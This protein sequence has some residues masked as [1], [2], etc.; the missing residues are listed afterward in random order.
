MREFGSE[1]PA[2]ILP[3]GYFEN[4]QRPGREIVH[5][6]SGREALLLVALNCK[7]ADGAVI[8]IPA[9][10]CWSMSA[11]FEKSG[12]EIVY[13]RLNEDLTPDEGY[14][15][16]VLESRRPAAILTMNFYGSAPTERAVALARE[17]CPGITII[18]DFSHCTFCF[19]RIFNPEVDFYVSSIRKSVGVCDGAIIIGR[20][21]LDTRLIIA[22]ESGF[23]DLR[24][25]AQASKDRYFHTKDP[26]AKQSFLNDLRRCETQ[27]D[28]FD[29]PH[30]MSDRARRMLACL[31]GEKI[32][33]ARR[34]NM[35]H[36]LV[37]LEEAGMQTVPGLERSLGG[38]PFSLPV[39]VERRDEVQREL[40]RNGVYAP[41]LWP[42]CDR[43][44]ETCPVS[45]RMAD[46]M[47]SLP[48][49]QR[50]GRDD[51]EEIARIVISC[52]R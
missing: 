24:T 44:R 17:K 47:L 28:D 36:L 16:G 43:A 41:V 20:K 18:E 42:L 35:K 31:N 5:L 12:W 52:K 34:E 8:L 6:R 33:F 21:P 48:V 13:Y 11:P 3:D 46:R 26:D 23:S 14:L 2:I 15:A 45:A 25:A 38:A 10:C 29:R 19:E 49:D 39:L 37:R 32:A 30:P 4:L 40:A 1:H 9:Y 51:M 7:P 22:D 50:Y 27:L